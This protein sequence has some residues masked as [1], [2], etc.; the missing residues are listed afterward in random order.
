WELRATGRRPSKI[1]R[2]LRQLARRIDS[3][4]AALRRLSEE[5]RDEVDS[6]IWPGFEMPKNFLDAE[7]P[8]IPRNPYIQATQKKPARP[9]SR[10]IA[11]QSTYYIDPVVITLTRL[12]GAIDEMLSK[13]NKGGAPLRLS[14]HDLAL[15]VG[16]AIREHLGV[17]PSSSSGGQFEEMLRGC[18]DVGL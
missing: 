4:L 6:L 5:A 3:L 18:L 16:L 8:F 15:K 14:W 13:Q 11:P 1:K 12:R 9:K 17:E 2:E 7:R 10:E